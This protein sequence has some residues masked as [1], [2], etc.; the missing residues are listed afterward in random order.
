MIISDS[1]NE[2]MNRFLGVVITAVFVVSLSANSLSHRP[3]SM[4]NDSA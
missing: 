4:G 2:D 3:E 1:E